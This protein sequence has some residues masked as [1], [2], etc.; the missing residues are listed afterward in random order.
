MSLCILFMILLYSDKALDLF[1]TK[2]SSDELLERCLFFQGSTLVRHCFSN[3]LYL[4]AR[5]RK[6]KTRIWLLNFLVKNVPT[7]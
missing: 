2:Y 6:S 5:Q 4:L 1:M 7:D 3:F